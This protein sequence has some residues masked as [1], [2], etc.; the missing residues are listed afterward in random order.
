MKRLLFLFAALFFAGKVPAC[1]C[2]G[3][4]TVE[5]GF[6]NSDAVFTGT[7]IGTDTIRPEPVNVGTEVVFFPY[8]RDFL[9][10]VETSYKG[11]HVKDTVRILTGLGGGDCGFRFQ[12]GKSYI[13]YAYK[14][15]S[16]AL[17]TNI[18]KRT[19]RYNAE[20]AAA[21]N[22]LIRPEPKNEKEKK[23]LPPAGSSGFHSADSAAHAVTIH[24]VYGSKPARGHKDT[25]H[26]YFGGIHG[27]HV[28]LQLDSMLFS[29]LPGTF[30][31]HIFAHGK[32]RQSLYAAHA[33][34]DFASDTVGAKVTSITY[35]LSD[36]QYVELNTVRQEYIH[37][38]PYDYAFFGMRCAAAAYDVL[39]HAGLVKKKGNFRNVCTNFYPKPMRKRMLKH[40]Q[41][42]GLKVVTKEG[43]A[44]RKW[45]KD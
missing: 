43:R 34:T 6:K 38:T 11:V 27:G 31:V 15:E 22:Q 44:S 32:K 23:V 9:F 35:P 19:T 30:P 25:E 45:E 14:D 39:G 18:C 21:L 41:Q 33:L 2:I 12:A 37:E 8:R 16:K 5:G 24:F 1:T 28:Y 26:H 13:V 36:S 7:V 4:S 10:L 17:H 42:H 3:E 40:A 29:F 20:E